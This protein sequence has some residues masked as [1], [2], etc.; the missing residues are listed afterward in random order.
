MPKY[1]ITTPTITFR[2]FDTASVIKLF[3][4]EPRAATPVRKNNVA[5]TNPAENTVKSIFC[6]LSSMILAVSRLPQKAIVS[7]LERVNIKPW[8]NMLLASVCID[9]PGIKLMSNAPNMMFAPKITNISAPTAFADFLTFS[10]SSSLLA[11]KQA[12]MI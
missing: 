12:K 7:G 2:D 5:E 1:A 8:I 3:K 11:P 6:I 4:T 10:F 9:N